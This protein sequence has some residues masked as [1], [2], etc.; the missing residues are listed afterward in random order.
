LLSVLLIAPIRSAST[1]QAGPS[2]ALTWDGG[3]ANASW[4]T[5]AN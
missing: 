1:C 2:P 3:G 5:A 4:G